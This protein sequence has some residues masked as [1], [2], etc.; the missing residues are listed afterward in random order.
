MDF[1]HGIARTGVDE[2][3][4]TFFSLLLHS[5]EEMV[6]RATRTERDNHSNNL[7]VSFKLLQ[8]PNIR[9]SSLLIGSLIEILIIIGT[10]LKVSTVL[11]TVLSIVLAA[12]EDAGQFAPHLINA[13]LLT[14]L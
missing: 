8:Q 14:L 6:I 7:L 1:F 4:S 9:A 11:A 10:V 2:H 3:L 5:G 13:D 12:G